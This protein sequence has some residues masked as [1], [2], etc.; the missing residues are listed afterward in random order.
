M[1]N[2]AEELDRV[3]HALSNSTRREVVARLTEGPA[4]MSVLAQPFE[5]ALPTFLQHLQ[6]LEGAGLVTS[7]K[8]G[9]TRLFRLDSK[10]LIEAEHWIDQHRTQWETRLNQLDEFLIQLKENQK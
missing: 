8:V 5:I 1:A 9:R 3:F 4:A 7:K 2:H 6:V 10:R